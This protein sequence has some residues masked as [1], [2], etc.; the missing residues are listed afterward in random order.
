MAFELSNLKARGYKWCRVQQQK[1]NGVFLDMDFDDPVQ[2]DASY[3]ILAVEKQQ[4]KEP[5]NVPA[6]TQVQVKI[7]MIF[8]IKDHIQ[9]VRNDADKMICYTIMLKLFL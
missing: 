6:N 5:E 2:Q 3:R 4:P 7:K 1:K 8:Y 9:K